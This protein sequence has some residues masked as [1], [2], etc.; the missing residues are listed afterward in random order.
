[1]HDRRNGLPPLSVA[2]PPIADAPRWIE[3]DALFAIGERRFAL[4]ADI[5]AESIEAVMKP[6][7]RA[8]REIVRSGTID[9]DFGV[10]NLFV[11]FVTTNERRAVDRLHA[12]RHRRRPPAVRRARAR[13]GL[14]ATPSIDEQGAPKR[15]SSADSH[16]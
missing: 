6:K 7:I 2:A 1:M 11:L 12:M 15:F 8:Y 14:T 13:R 4:E 16:L 3:P 9:G 5:G 10:D